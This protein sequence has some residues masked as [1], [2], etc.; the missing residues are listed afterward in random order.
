MKLTYRTSVGTWGTMDV[1]RV[2]I[3]YIEDTNIYHVRGFDK[4]EYPVRA[5]IDVVEYNAEQS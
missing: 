3:D 5:I 4:D 1:H 2:A